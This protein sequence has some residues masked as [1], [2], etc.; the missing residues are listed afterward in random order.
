M[1]DSLL[2]AIVQPANLIGAA[3]AI[4]TFATVLTIALPLFN[5]DR[6]EARMK[7]VAT[8]REE[9]RR[10]SRAAIAGPAAGAACAAPTTAASRASW[11][12]CSSRACSRILRWSRT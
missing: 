1:D 6:L 12:A 2:V 11:S 7:S 5:G 4:L 10:A 3:V 9:L 8:R